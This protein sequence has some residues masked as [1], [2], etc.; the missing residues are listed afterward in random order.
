[1]RCCQSGA[2]VW[3]AAARQQESA[4]GGLAEFCGEE[5]RR[6]ELANDEVLDGGGIGEKK[7]RVGRFVDVGEAEDEAVVGGHGFDVGTAGGRDLCGGGHSPGSVDAIAEGS[8]DADAPVAELVADA[9]DDDVAIIWNGGGY[10]C[11]IGEELEEIF[12]GLGVEVVFADEAADGRV[13][14][15]GAEFADERADA[16]A[17]FEGTASADRH[18]RR[19]FCRAGRERA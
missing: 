4:G 3:A 1:M 7:V 18:A 6:A 19:A 9:L 14:R 16:A 12:G 15:E 11:L 10:I 13:R 5:R 2:R 8:E 17:E